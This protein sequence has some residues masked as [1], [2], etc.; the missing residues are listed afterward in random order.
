M[1]QEELDELMNSDLD[2]DVMNDEPQDAQESENHSSGD[3]DER[4]QLEKNY[5]VHSEKSWPPPPPN[6]E[7]QVVTQLDDVTRESE[8]KAT[9]IFDI[10]DDISNSTNDIAQTLSVVSKAMKQASDV[11]EKL[12]NHFPQMETFK[13]NKS[14]LEEAL[15]IVDEA[16]D[17]LMEVGDNTLIAMDIMQYQDI[18]RQKIERVINVMRSLSRYLNQLFEAQIDDS[19]R[20]S[21]AKHIVGD[22]TD[23][24]VED[25]DIEAL[26]AAFGQK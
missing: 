18:H 26:I 10:L 16:N 11:F 13:T 21:S 25:D 17:R 23:D 6:K 14:A 15:L 24:V 20:V 7:H 4:Q 9:E 1:T 22:K 5:N 3:D 8:Q 2:L 12:E 19:K